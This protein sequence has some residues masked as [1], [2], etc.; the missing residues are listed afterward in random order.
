[1]EVFDRILLSEVFHQILVGA[2]DRVVAELLPPDMLHGRVFRSVFRLRG[3][4]LV[5]EE[6][7]VG[8]AV[9]SGYRRQGDS[10]ARLLA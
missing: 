6:L 1:M 8:L 9:G 2:W 3:I 5:T 7:D 4:V 10:V